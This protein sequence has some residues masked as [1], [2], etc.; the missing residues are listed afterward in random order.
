MPFQYSLHYIE[1]PGGELLHKEFLAQ[2]DTDPRRAISEA[3]CKDIPL[4]ACTLA[5]N[6]AFEC[7][8]IRELSEDFPDL[9]NHLLDIKDHILDLMVPFYNREYYMKDMKGSYSIKYVLPAIFPDD[10]SLNYHNLDLVHNGGEAMSIFANLGSYPK[11]E[12]EYIRE[13]LLR[14]C[15]LDTYAMVKI[16]ENLV[17]VA[18]ENE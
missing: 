9:A 5:Y 4:G 11:E 8:R 15:E 14:Y 17:E 16:W 10:P 1:K 7:T 6:K 2:A 12:Q 18:K 3:L 13:R